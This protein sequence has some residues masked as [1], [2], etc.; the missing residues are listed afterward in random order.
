[1]TALEFLNQDTNWHGGVT[2]HAVRAMIGFAKLKV[3]EALDIAAKRENIHVNVDEY[4][5]ATGY[6]DYIQDS[7]LKSY[8]LNTIE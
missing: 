8:K 3:K 5:N 7:I 2:D 6:F 4:G 1:M